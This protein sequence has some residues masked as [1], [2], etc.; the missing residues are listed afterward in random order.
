ME[1]RT[2]RPLQILSRLPL[3]ISTVFTQKRLLPLNSFV[4]YSSLI[5]LLFHSLENLPIF[6]ALVVLNRITPGAPNVDALASVSL[7]LTNS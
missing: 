6:G 2:L 4:D 5:A 1:M 3:A 7:Q